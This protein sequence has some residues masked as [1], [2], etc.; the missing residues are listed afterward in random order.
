MKAILAIGAVLVFT[1]A[2]AG[3]ENVSPR[4]RA[5]QA[6]E[7]AKGDPARWYKED[8]T[9]AEHLTR[10]R[11]EAQAAHR[12]NI[13]ECKGNKQCIIEAH[14]IYAAELKDML[15]RLMREIH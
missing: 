5:Q 2:Y 1:A 10:F 14:N 9:V 3:D 13:G 7:I 15:D 6:A 4:M 12:E 11:K 8:R